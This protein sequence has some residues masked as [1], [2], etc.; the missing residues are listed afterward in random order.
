MRATLVIALI[1]LFPLP[2]SGGPVHSESSYTTLVIEYIGKSDRPLFPI[3]ISAS[4]EE[5]EWYR[6]HLSNDLLQDFI[7]VNVVQASTLKE[8]TD[9]PLFKGSLARPTYTDHPVTTPTVRFLLGVGYDHTETKVDAQTGLT[10]LV[11]ID[12]Y[13]AKYPRLGSELSEVEHRV[14][15]QMPK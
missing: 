13:I 4:T 8:I 10:I 1:L 2:F 7:D 11:A 9:L 14:R 12:R 6:Q 15:Y 3:V 5:G